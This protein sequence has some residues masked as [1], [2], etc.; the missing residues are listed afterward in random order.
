[1][2]NKIVHILKLCAKV[3]LFHTVQCIKVQL[4]PPLCR[5]FKP[6]G[7]L[8]TTRQRLGGRREGEGYEMAEVKGG[9][10][11]PEALDQLRSQCTTRQQQGGRWDGGGDEM[12]EVKG[13]LALPEALD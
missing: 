13:G 3:H 7:I 9:L 6:S 2:A 8:F 1:M 10:A 12:A 11:L 4:S 5:I